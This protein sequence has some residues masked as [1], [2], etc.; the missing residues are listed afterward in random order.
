MTLLLAILGLFLLSLGAGSGVEVFVMAI[1]GAFGTIIV[2]G[3]KKYSGTTTISGNKALT[4]T[5]I[6]SVA[7]SIIGAVLTNAFSDVSGAINV[8][9]IINGAATVFTVATLAYK[10]LLSK[11]STPTV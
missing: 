7:L 5:V 4:I 3:I 9:S 8:F 1:L 6:V 2:Q 10:Y 11:D